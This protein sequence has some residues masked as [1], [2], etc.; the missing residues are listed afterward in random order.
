MDRATIT[1]WRLNGVDWTALVLLIIG[2][3]NWGLV[4]FFNFDLVE[5]LFGEM[6]VISRIVYVIV[7]LSALWSI[8]SLATH[9]HHRT[10]ETPGTVTR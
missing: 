2:G 4:G 5:A 9:L 8:I 10:Y 7:G 6:S 3:L 1:D